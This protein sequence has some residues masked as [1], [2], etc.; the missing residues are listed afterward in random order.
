MPQLP[1]RIEMQHAYLQRDAA[2]DGVFFLGV[3]TTGIFCRPSCGARKPQ[4]RNVDFF[5]TAREALFAGY[6]PCKRCSPLAAPGGA[7]RLG[8]ASP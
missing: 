5:A 8:T 2:Y 1:S 7:A 4:P 3:R 6:R